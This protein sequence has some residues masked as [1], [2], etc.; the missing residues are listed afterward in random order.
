M[1]Q[2]WRM[3]EN[4]P[5]LRPRPV[6]CVSKV[7]LPYVRLP[8]RNGQATPAGATRHTTTTT[9]DT[10]DNGQRPGGRASLAD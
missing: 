4:E 8:S 3:R 9:D 5:V 6:V 7:L 2:E 10:P 1:I